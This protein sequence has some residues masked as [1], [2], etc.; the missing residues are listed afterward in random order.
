RFIIAPPS[1]LRPLLLTPRSGLSCLSV[2]PRVP[3][4]VGHVGAVRGSPVAAVP[5]RAHPAQLHRHRAQAAHRGPAQSDAIL[6]YLVSRC[7]LAD[8][9][10]PADPR[11]RARVDEYTAFHHTHT[12]P[13]AAKVFILEVLIPAQTRSPVDAPALNRALSDLDQTLDLI[14]SMF[15]RRQAFLCGTDVSVADLLCV[16]ELMQPLGGDRDVLESRPLL[17][18]WRSRVQSAVGPAFDNAHSVLYAVRER[19]K[20]R[21]TDQAKL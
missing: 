2:C 6:K 18:S 15:L 5:R 3:V 11:R 21:P 9:W 17:R 1:A 20:A 12:R 19:F 10:Y 8:H 14:Q 16:C 13:H 7:G 4:S